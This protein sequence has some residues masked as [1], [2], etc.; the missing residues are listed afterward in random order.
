M[1]RNNNQMKREAQL[2]STIFTLY[3]HVKNELTIFA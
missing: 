1:L 2:G 3:V